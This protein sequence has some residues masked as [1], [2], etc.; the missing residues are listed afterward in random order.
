MSEIKPVTLWSIGGDFR[1]VDANDDDAPLA[2]LKLYSPFREMAIDK[3]QTVAREILEELA[4]TPHPF[5]EEEFE[6]E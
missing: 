1:I 3:P 2:E 4:R 5:A 6:D